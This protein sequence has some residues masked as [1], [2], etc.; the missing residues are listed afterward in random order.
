M[1]LMIISLNY[2]TYSFGDL[3]HVDFYTSERDKLAIHAVV[4]FQ[5]TIEVNIQYS[6][7]TI[8]APIYLENSLWF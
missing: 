8:P 3:D 4:V 5:L 2:T 1:I 7:P 6:Y